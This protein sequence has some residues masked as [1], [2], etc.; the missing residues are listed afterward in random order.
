MLCGQFYHRR[1]KISAEERAKPVFHV[2]SKKFYLLF[3]FERIYYI[4]RPL[5]VLK[6][7]L[8]ISLMTQWYKLFNICSKTHFMANNL[9][10]QFF[11]LFH[12]IFASHLM[13][14]SH[15]FELKIR[16]LT[17]QDVKKKHHREKRVGNSFI[18]VDRCLMLRFF[19]Q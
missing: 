9:L 13:F 8:A 18:V 11:N 17:S 14:I 3:Q 19:F 1:S 4:N 10:R 2:I 5:N 16:S 12:I 15:C 6:C 7:L